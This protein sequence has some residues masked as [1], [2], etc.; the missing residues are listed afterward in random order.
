MAA[1]MATGLAEYM[2]GLNATLGVLTMLGAFATAGELPMF[3][4]ICGDGTVMT[5]GL[6]KWQKCWHDPNFS[7]TK[8]DVFNQFDL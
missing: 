4:A 8:P 3:R 7:M 5:Y 6:E 2:V 1:G